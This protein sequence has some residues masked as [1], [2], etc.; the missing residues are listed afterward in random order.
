MKAFWVFRAESMT[1]L[2]W[3][4]GSGAGDWHSP[5]PY[6]V[7]LKVETVCSWKHWN[8]PTTLHGATGQKTTV[9]ATTTVK[10]WKRILTW[11]SLWRNSRFVK[12]YFVFQQTLSSEN[13]TLWN[14]TP[15]IKF[16]IPVK[17]STYKMTAFNFLLQKHSIMYEIQ[18]IFTSKS[19]KLKIWI[20][21]IQK[22][23]NLGHS[24]F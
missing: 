7:T 6:S 12:T 20:S 1:G 4:F 19:F 14:P 16:H 21:A 2:L 13:E 24:S 18:H 8:K 9:S 23:L 15:L 17:Q 3:N 11:W 22:L 5:G 10:T